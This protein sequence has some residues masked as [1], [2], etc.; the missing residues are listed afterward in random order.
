MRISSL[1]ELQQYVSN[2]KLTAPKFEIDAGRIILIPRL[3]NYNI[4]T[5]IIALPAFAILVQKTENVTAVMSIAFLVLFLYFLWSDFNAV[6]KV[7]IDFDNDQ[8]LVKY[9]SPFRLLLSFMDKHRQRS[10]N[11]SSLNGFFC[12]ESGLKP[13]RFRLYAERKDIP[14]ILLI[15]FS[16]EEHAAKVADYLNNAMRE[17]AKKV[18][19]R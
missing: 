16:Y 2:A 6:N 7:E 14:D 12:K 17:A 5:N 13:Q 18:D 10:F 11:I 8:I 15:D 9:R 4:I 3:V 1:E 19:R